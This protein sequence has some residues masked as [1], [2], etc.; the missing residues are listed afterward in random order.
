MQLSKVTSLGAKHRWVMV[1]PGFYD[2]RYVLGLADDK[3]PAEELK[4][5]QDNTA[6]LALFGILF[7]AVFAYLAKSI[8]QVAEA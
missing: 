7:A 8:L 1:C 2:R 5:A 4:K 3:T 6:F